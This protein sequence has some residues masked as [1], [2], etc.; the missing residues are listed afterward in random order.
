MGGNDD[1]EWDDVK[2][3]TNRHRRGLPLPIAARLF[4][5]R[6]RVDGVSAKSRSDETR[7]ETMAELEGRVAIL[8]LEME[9]CPPPY[10]FASY[11]ASE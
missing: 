4:D 7:F 5:G 11:C 9:R 6:P 2:D 1:F 8:R 10:Y 3:A